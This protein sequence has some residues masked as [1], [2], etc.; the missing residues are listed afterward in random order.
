M[1]DWLDRAAMVLG[2]SFM[3]VSVVLCLM[4]GVILAADI[5]YRRTKTLG[6]LWTFMVYHKEFFAW[7]EARKMEAPDA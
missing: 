3:A 6:H 5:L 7:R 1:P 2:Y 4:V